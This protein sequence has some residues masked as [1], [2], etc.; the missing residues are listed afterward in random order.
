MINILVILFCIYMFIKTDIKTGDKKELMWL[1][2]VGIL[3]IVISARCYAIDFISFWLFLI[4]T[5]IGLGGI[6]KCKYV[7][8]YIEEEGE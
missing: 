5:T 8:G 1:R 7:E 2:I 3:F 4:L 6:F